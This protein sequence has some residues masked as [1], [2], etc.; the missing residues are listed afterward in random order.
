MSPTYTYADLIRL[1]ALAS[2]LGF[3]DDVEHW[4]SLLEEQYPEEAS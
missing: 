1:I 4:K 3:Q 2:A